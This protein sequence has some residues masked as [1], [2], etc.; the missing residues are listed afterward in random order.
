MSQVGYTTISI[1]VP[2]A[3]RLRAEKGSDE[4][5]SELVHRLCSCVEEGEA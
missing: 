4:T 3:E 2:A 1:E 5:F